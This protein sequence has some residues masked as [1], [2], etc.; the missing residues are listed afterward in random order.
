MKVIGIICEF[1]IFAFQVVTL[2]VEFNA[3][4]RALR[5]VQDLKFV[6]EKEYTYCKKMLTAAALTYV[7]SVA[8]AILEIFRLVLMANNRRR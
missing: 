3:S 7:A 6:Q 2:P 1:V 8:T 4:S 5:Q